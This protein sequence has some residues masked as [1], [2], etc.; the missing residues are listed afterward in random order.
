MHNPSY[1][2]HLLV[3]RVVPL[4]LILAVLLVLDQGC[5][6]NEI[7]MQRCSDVAD[8]PGSDCSTDNSAQQQAHDSVDV[9]S[10]CCR[11]EVAILHAMTQ[12]FQARNEMQARTTD[13]LPTSTRSQQKM[14]FDRTIYL[15][16]GAHDT[17][18]ECRGMKNDQNCDT[19]SRLWKESLDRYAKKKKKMSKA[20]SLSS[21]PEL[22]VF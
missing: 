22:T 19:S 3:I 6:D 2:L 7:N 11:A 13:A 17:L 5:F 15:L 8:P 1:W 14:L 9:D 18:T 10:A 21:I 16:R 20:A 12:V 4:L